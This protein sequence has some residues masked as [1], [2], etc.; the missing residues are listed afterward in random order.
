MRN[1]HMCSSGLKHFMYDLNVV[2]LS[3][4]NQAKKLNKLAVKVTKNG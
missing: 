4:A 1:V 2:K 3:Q